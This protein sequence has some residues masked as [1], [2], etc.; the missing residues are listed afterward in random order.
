MVHRPDL[1]LRRLTPDNCRALLFDDVLWVKRARQEH[2]TFV[3]A[4]RE[5]GVIVHLFGELLAECMEIAAARQWLLDRRVEPSIVGMDLEGDLRGWLETLPAAEIAT[6][7]IGGV[8]RAELPF[9]PQGLTGRTLER[10]DFVLPPLPNQL[11]VRDSSCWVGGMVSV[12]TMFWPARRPEALNV[13]AVYRFHPRFRGG[14]FGFLSDEHHDGSSLEGGDVMPIGNGVVLV[15]M[16]ERSTPQAVV[17]LARRL[18]KAGTATRVIAALMPRDRSFMHLDTVFTLCDRDLATLYPPVV[19]RLRTYSLRP[20]SAAETVDV[21]EEELPFTQ[22]VADA[23]GV[24]RLRVIATGGDTYEAE[25]EQWDDGNNV[26]AIE[27]GVVV[28]YDRNVYTNTLLR[29]AGVEVITIEGAELSRGRGGG[30]C[31]TCPLVRD[32]T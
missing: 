16:G 22:V 24:P 13:E 6:Y 5:R 3:D 23:L 21:T 19:D 25:R 20:G 15:G 29:R 1:S 4:L 2:D 30:H 17:A 14:T 11:F 9:E 10:R 7:L 26:V 32:A 28:A 18:F 31:M 8:A 27:P 12:N